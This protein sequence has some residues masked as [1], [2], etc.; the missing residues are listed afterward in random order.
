M[1]LSWVVEELILGV[2]LLLI[3]ARTSG[4]TKVIG[5]T[6]NHLK[7]LGPVLEDLDYS[8]HMKTFFE[9]KSGNTN[10]DINAH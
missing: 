2:F 10:N 3:Y 8:L 7:N 6:R 5:K 4:N 9:K 1:V